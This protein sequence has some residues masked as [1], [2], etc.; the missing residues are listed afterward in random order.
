MA[1]SKSAKKRNRQ[2][3][4]HRLRNRSRLS[5]TRTAVKTVVKAA[6]SAS[7]GAAS[8]DR[9]QAEA[10]YRRAASELDRAARHRVVHPNAAARTKSRLAKRIAKAFGDAAAR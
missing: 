2:N 3:E 8:A 7:S 4:T 10:L 6:T 5:R 1:Q 9:A